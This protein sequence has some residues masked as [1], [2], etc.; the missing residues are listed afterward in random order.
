MQSGRRSQGLKFVLTGALAVALGTPAKA[1]DW[2]PAA[3]LGTDPKGKIVAV[4]EAAFHTGWFGNQLRLEKH[5]GLEYRRAIRLGGRDCILAVQGP[6][7]RRRAYGL[8][9]ELRF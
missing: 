7:V 3:R 5:S 6:V 8:G 2:E 1:G 4:I 9:F